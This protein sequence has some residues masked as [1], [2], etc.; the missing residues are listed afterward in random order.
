MISDKKIEFLVKQSFERDIIK[1]FIDCG[2]DKHLVWFLTS[3]K[4]GLIPNLN[5]EDIKM[6]NLYLEKFASANKKNQTTTYSDALI[7]ARR[8]DLNEKRKIR[9]QIY[10]FK[11]GFYISIL[12]VVDL[13]DEGEFM[14]NCVGSYEG[15]VMAGLVGILA[16]KYPSGKTA[17]HI[18]IKKNGLIGQNYAKANTQ[19]NKECWMMI[20]EFFENNSKLVDLSKA[21]GESYVTTHHGGCIKEILLTI[22]T[23]V[24]MMIDNGVKISEQVSGFEI[25]RF[26][27]FHGEKDRA[28]KMN[29]Q[30]EVVEWIEQKKRD[31]ITIYD[32]LIIQ[33]LSTSASK[34]YLSDFMKDKI[35]GTKKGAYLMKGNNYNLSEIDPRYGQNMGYEDAQVPVRMDERE[36]MEPVME[37]DGELAQPAP[38]DEYDVAL[39]EMQ[40]EFNEI[41]ADINEA[42]E[43]TAPARR[44]PVILLGRLNDNV[45]VAM[46]DRVEGE[47]PERPQLIVEER[48]FN[49]EYNAEAREEDDFEEIELEA[50][51]VVG[52]EEAEGAE[53]H[54][55]QGHVIQAPEPF[56]EMIR[57]AERR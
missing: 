11:N 51:D 29:S 45:D 47:R 37:N 24:N 54:D 14:A 35:F 20:L 13:M 48:P 44:R 42:M 18:E 6:V 5:I 43:I 10:H 31:I 2:V 23:S 4:K 21:F 32:E 3:H 22:P 56:V 19:L 27:P 28:I 40:A 34:L 16:L 26:A 33:T 9:N 52:M 15:K 36:I 8:F 49:G 55:V 53:D 38:H 17:A 57:R 39:N 50:G 7:A 30:S 12:N 1:M 46:V 41:N 25:K